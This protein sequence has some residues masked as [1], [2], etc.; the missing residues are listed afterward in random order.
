MRVA[1]Y[2]RYSD[3]VQNPASIEDQ[4]RI[5]IRHC[6]ARGWTVVAHYTDAA[7]SADFVVTRPGALAL[8]AAADRREFD[9]ILVEHQDRLF[10]DLADHTAAFKRLNYVG[11]GIA[12]LRTDRVTKLDVAFEGLMSEMYLDILSAKTKRGLHA[13]A[14]AGK[15]TG[16]RTFGYRS[17]PGGKVE[18]HAEEADVV[19][20]AFARFAA[21][22]TGMEI[23]RDFNAQGVPG[24][25][26]GAWT[27]AG[28]TGSRQRANG[29]L[30]CEMYNG[31]KVWNR[32]SYAKDP[33]T[34]RK[35]LTMRPEAEWKR[36][37]V[38]ELAIID[39][40]TWAAVEARFAEI[41]KTRPAQLAGRVNAG[42]FTGLLKCGC[43]GA[44]I[45]SIDARRM[46]CS[47]AK[48]RGPAAC[49]NGRVMRRNEI[50]QR[51]LDGLRSQL[52][53]PEATAAYVRAYHAAWAA[54]AGQRRDRRGPIQKRLAEVERSIT[55]IVDAIC[56]GSDTPAMT[57][58]LKDLE[59][60]K[61]TLTVDLQ[62]IGP[63][64]PVQLHPRAAELYAKR[65][66]VLQARLG[67][68]GPKPTFKDRQLMDAVRALADRITLT[69]ISKEKWAH[70]KIDVQG[71][72]AQFLHPVTEP[73]SVGFRLVAGGGI[74]PPTCGL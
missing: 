16:G 66:E 2:A 7:I 62:T 57:A 43:C 59:A 74:E 69:P 11:V 34:G 46:K 58:R 35:I 27:S 54:K 48:H 21:G 15:S 61:A 32:F 23:A 33:A 22:E 5:L 29:V 39:P 55:R 65:V 40:E 26:G 73:P 51:I 41:G 17:S 64:E 42:L 72:L 67:Q 68:I 53:T 18:I 3:A 49:D 1:L 10:R 8:L 12:T 60:E 4:L 52:L 19:R 9:L 70:V 31:V 13:N 25:S 56:N 28:L 24:P 71:D 37:A 30:R 20:T 63:D 38:P 36:T 45:I 50:E 47:T 14:E 6:Q 44:N